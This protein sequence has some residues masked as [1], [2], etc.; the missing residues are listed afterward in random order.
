ME[1]KYP[2][3]TQ[4]AIHMPTRV[5]KTR[6]GRRLSQISG[7]RVRW[8]EVGNR[9]GFHMHYDILYENRRS[10]QLTADLMRNFMAS[11]HG[12]IALHDHM[13]VHKHAQPA[14]ANPAFLN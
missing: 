3:G 1:R 9:G 2:A 14:L 8:L 11:P 13:D 5:G 6:I 7:G 10:L 4:L 12:Q